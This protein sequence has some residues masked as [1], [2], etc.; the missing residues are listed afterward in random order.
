MRREP[1]YNDKDSRSSNHF[2][3]GWGSLWGPG[4][5]YWPCPLSILPTKPGA[6]TT[7]LLRLRAADSR[8]GARGRTILKRMGKI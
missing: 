1:I 3:S 6:K 8:S 2:F 7:A 4:A 5:D